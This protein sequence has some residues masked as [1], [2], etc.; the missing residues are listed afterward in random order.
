MASAPLI[1]LLYDRTFVKAGDSRKA[2]RDHRWVYGGMS[3]TWALVGYLALG[4]G[5]RGGTA[6]FRTG[7]PWRIYAETQFGAVAHY[8]GLAAWPHPLVFD[9]GAIWVKAPW[10]IVP[11]AI[12]FAGL[13]AATAVALWRRPAIGLLGASFFS[14]L[15]PTSLVPV[16]VQTMAE[17]RMY[18]ALAPVLISAVWTIRGGLVQIGVA[19][20]QLPIFLLLG[21]AL[22]L[23]TAARN[24]DYRSNLTLWTLTASQRPGNPRTHYYRGV[25]LDEDGRPEDGMREMRT[26][27]ELDPDYPEAHNRL[28]IDWMNLGQAPDAVAHYEAAI[29]LKPDYAEAHYNRGT[30]FAQSGARCRKR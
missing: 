4:A 9:Y 17:H 6:G 1:V 19:R 14:I 26:A 29:R 28:G 25:A 15:A 13:L 30:A 11:S 22:G 10:E 24:R 18:L 16:V 20:I 7:A 27:L 5:S 21:L 3:C 8:L 23:T 12:I 2:L